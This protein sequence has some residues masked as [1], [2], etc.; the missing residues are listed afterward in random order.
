MK[1]SFSPIH[2][3]HRSTENE[4]E[5]I[6][7]NVI[8]S[9][10]NLRLFECGYAEVDNNWEKIVS[11]FP[12][13]RIYLVTEGEA[14][15]K[16]K[17]STIN[18]E[19][20][21]LYYIPSF[22]IVSGNCVNSFKHYYIHFSPNSKATCLLDLYKPIEKIKFKQ[23]DVIL[24]EELLNSFPKNDIA[25]SIRKNSIFKYLLAKFYDNAEY[26]NNDM[27]RFEKVIT[28]INENIH[29][30]INT[31]TLASVANLS[32]AYFSN[33]FS[34]TFGISPIKF[35]NQKKMNAAAIM[36][37]EKN[38]Y[39]KEIA[40]ALGY[41][42]EMYFYRLFKKN[43]GMTPSQYK[44]ESTKLLYTIKPNTDKNED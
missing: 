27:L 13:F 7:T 32:E 3:F 11:T 36:L 43:F 44:K 22:Q 9:I 4:I 10:E 31:S 1:K 6:N 38:L 41:D 14:K 18:L 39:T 17:N 15:L 8:V 21:Y 28:Y 2:I 37:T 19:Q 40:Y 12:Y 29:M 24:F 25:N 30:H 5:K 26:H 35:I 33:I 34:K 23:S 16:L 42:N 20:G